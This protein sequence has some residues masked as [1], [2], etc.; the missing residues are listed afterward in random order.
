MNF[1][2]PI[3]QIFSEA[4][5]Y[6]LL[7]FNIE[8]NLAKYRSKFIHFYFERTADKK[9]NITEIIYFN[10]AREMHQKARLN[11]EK[12]EWFEIYDNHGHIDLLLCRFDRTG[13][14][15]VVRENKTRTEDW[16]LG[17]ADEKPHPPMTR[18]EIREAF[19]ELMGDFQD[20]Q[21]LQ[22]LR[23]KKAV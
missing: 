18:D 19:Q 11:I 7:L 14:R 22:E 5:F 2:N 9:M 21:N 1:E 12:K 17:W 16:R 15:S 3:G 8:E 23:S 4:Q 10:N 13:V 20:Q 6:E